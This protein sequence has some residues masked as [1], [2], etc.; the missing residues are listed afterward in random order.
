MGDYVILHGDTIMW[1][2]TFGKCITTGPPTG[3]TKGSS[4]KTKATGKKIALEGDEAQW[5]SMPIGYMSPPYVMPG[6]GFA[7]IMKLGPDQS[8]MKT[9]VEGKKAILKG[10][11]F[12]ALF[13]VMVPAMMP[14]PPSA[15]VPDPMPMY[16]GGM[17]KFITTNTKVKMG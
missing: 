16:P 14:A 2:P 13:M 1:M 7:K 10:S 4:A 15:P 17:G 5:K 6:M 12:T 9:K 11:M 3:M 8:T